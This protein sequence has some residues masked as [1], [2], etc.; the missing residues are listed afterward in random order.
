[1]RQTPMIDQQCILDT[2]ASVYTDPVV[3]GV[4]SKYYWVR[5]TALVPPQTGSQVGLKTITSPFAS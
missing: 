3:E 2:K 4:V 5:H 1:M